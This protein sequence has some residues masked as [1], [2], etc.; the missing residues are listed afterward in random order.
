MGP[1]ISDIHVQNKKYGHTD[2]LWTYEGAKIE[3][4]K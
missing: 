4:F 3:R 1:L 2:I